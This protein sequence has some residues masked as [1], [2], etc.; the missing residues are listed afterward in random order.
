VGETKTQAYTNALRVQRKQIQGAFE[1]FSQ[2]ALIL[3]TVEGLR[4]PI[5]LR[6]T[7]ARMTRC[8]AKARTVRRVRPHDAR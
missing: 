1:W 8:S 2:L 5:A 3:R 4:T 6:P 7:S